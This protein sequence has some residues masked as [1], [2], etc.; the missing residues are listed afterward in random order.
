MVNTT[1]IDGQESPSTVLGT[2]RMEEIMKKHTWVGI[3]TAF[4]LLTASGMSHAAG[5]GFTPDAMKGDIAGMIQLVVAVIFGIFICVALG[6][7]VMALIDSKKYGFSHLAFALIAVLVAGIALFTI[8]SLAGQDGN[9]HFESLNE[10]KK[11][12]SK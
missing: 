5:S 10:S 3:V 1:Q 12:N 6:T 9:K 8:S 7:I 11:S 4:L 2:K